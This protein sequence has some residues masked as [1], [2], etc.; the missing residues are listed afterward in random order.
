MVHPVHIA[1][2]CSVESPEQVRTAALDIRRHAPDITVLRGGIWKPRTRPNSFEG[3]GAEALPWLVEAGRSAGL[4]VT[5]EVANPDHVE[6]ALA[7]GVDIVWLGARTTVSPFIVQSIADALRGC[8]VPVLI[9]NPVNPDV[10]LWLG[11]VERIEEAVTGHVAVIHRGF[12]TYGSTVYRNPPH[13]EIPLELRRLR[14]DLRIL[15]DPSHIGGRR[16]LIGPLSQQAMDLGFDGLM[17]ETHPTPDEALSDAAQQVT[18][19]RLGEILRGLIRR[20]DEDAEE[21]IGE[22]L[23]AMRGRI[24]DI[25]ARVIDLLGE[26]MGIAARIGDLKQLRDIAIHQP[27]RWS[28]VVR[29]GLDRGR[30]LGLSESFLLEFFQKVHH[31]SIQQQLGGVDDDVA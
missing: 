22:D 24:D 26:R 27:E 31:E 20:R 28:R 4:R 30:S 13:W 23:Q 14:P 7:A 18:P 5:T 11:A 2:P 21:S 3:R 6:A 10:K 8:E 16:S 1:G 12:S 9:K 15:C 19:A 29:N 25:D 17:V